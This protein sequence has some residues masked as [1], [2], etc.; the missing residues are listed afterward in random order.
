MNECF[1]A[2]ARLMAVVAG[3]TCAT[4]LAALELVNHSRGLLA[5]ALCAPSGR[6]HKFGP[7]LVN[8]RPRSGAIYKEGRQQQG[9]SDG[10]GNED[11]TKGHSEL[12]AAHV[13]PLRNLR[14]EQPLKQDSAVR[15]QSML[16]QLASPDWTPEASG[17][18]LP[19]FATRLRRNLAILVDEQANPRHRMAPISRLRP[20]ARSCRTS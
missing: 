5:M 3:D 18:S 2:I 16:P 9:A 4:V 10:D 1:L 14:P 8:F 6:A 12:V 20:R 19:L 11:R 7:R 17:S 15:P 13:S